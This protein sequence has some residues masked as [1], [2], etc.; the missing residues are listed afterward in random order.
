MPFVEIGGRR[1]LFVH[2]P[3]TGGSSVEEWLSGHGRL[4][5]GG[6]SAFLRGNAQHLPYK[7]HVNLFGGDFFDYAF[8]IVRSPY[9][10]AL[11]EYRM[12]IMAAGKDAMLH[13][14]K[15]NFWLEENLRRAETNPFVLDNHLRRQVEFCGDGL[16]I[17]RFED[18]LAN[19]L[20]TVA[21]DLGSPKPA[22]V[23]HRASTAHVPEGRMLDGPSILQL[24]EFYAADFAQFGYA[25]KTPDWPVTATS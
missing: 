24:N 20:A 8:A 21:A 25:P 10:R 3:K 5:F 9:E 11:S 4:R 17:F 7:D 1:V 12:R 18:G 13:P 22:D 23:P 6:G 2:I 15:L 19:I 16:R 14:P